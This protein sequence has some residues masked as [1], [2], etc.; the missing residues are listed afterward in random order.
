M[1]KAFFIKERLFKIVG[2]FIL[3]ISLVLGW[4]LFN[5]Q[6]F[7]STPLAVGEGVDIVIEPGKSLAAVA[8]GLFK[9][10]VMQNPRYFLLM[11]RVKN[12]A[13]RIQAGEYHLEPGATPVSLLDK[14]V[15]GDVV[16]YALTIVEGWD[17]H[18]LMVVVNSSPYLKHK[19][20]GLDNKTIMRRLGFEGQHPEGRFLPDTYHFPRGLSDIAFLQRA[21]RAMD[22][23]L[24][25]A[26]EKRDENLPLKS[27]YEVLIL[28]SIIEKETGQADER[29]AISGVFVRRLEQGIRLQTDPTVIYGL[30]LDFDGNLRRVHLQQQDNL[31]NTYRHKGLP[32]TPIAMPGA[33]AID[34][35]LH[36][37]P[38]DTL[39]F[40]SR[41]D[42]SHHFSATL[43]EHNNAVIKY[44]LKGRKRSFSSYSAQ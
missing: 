28:A 26:W 21:H 3:V 2:A 31:Y 33:A 29:P 39:Y 5:Y 38:G 30:G 41:G 32:P 14:L 11:A 10:G 35:A 9:Q 6:Q 40:V 8:N 20:K 18:E 7:A 16:N 4:F 22:K 37:A 43:R 24:A 34:A 1:N 19:L 12:V 36:P 42:G 44:Q 13:H 27:A 23:S 25:Q 15:V 17:F